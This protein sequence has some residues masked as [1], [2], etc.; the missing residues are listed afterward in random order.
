MDI[1]SYLRKAYSFRGLSLYMASVEETAGNLL[2]A[3]FFETRVNVLL[4]VSMSFFVLTNNLLRE[5]S[6]NNPDNAELTADSAN[7][8]KHVENFRKNVYAKVS[9][10]PGSSSYI[11]T[12]ADVMKTLD[13]LLDY[14][15][16]H[17][18]VQMPSGAG[19]YSEWGN[20]Y[21]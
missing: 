16:K 5:K 7:Y 4:Q 12:Q 9:Y 6:R 1:Y 17:K 8:A 20:S 13:L 19:K 14:A 10:A 2:N 21:E 11:Q 15:N 3:I 18:L